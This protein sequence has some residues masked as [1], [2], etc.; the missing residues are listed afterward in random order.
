MAC[1]SRIAV[2]SALGMG[3]ELGCLL[4]APRGRR[5]E[6]GEF[7][8]RI[9]RLIRHP[10]SRAYG[11]AGWSLIRSWSRKISTVL[12][13]P[14]DPY[15][16]ADIS[17]RQGVVGLVED[18]VM[19]GMD[20]ALLPQGTFEGQSRAAASDGASLRQGRRDRAFFFVV[21]WISMPISS[22]HQWRARSLA[23]LIS[24]KVLPARRCLLD[25]R[26]GPFDLSLMFGIS[27]LCRIGD[28]ADS[29]APCRHRRS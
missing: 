29:A 2:M 15:L 18:D 10:S 7:L 6:E 20:G 19:V 12:Y 21:P 24:V 25:D 11:T 17:R 14:F 28:K 27:H 26:H 16:L 4:S 22:L 1:S 13:V 3:T 8:R 23:S 5:H 9:V